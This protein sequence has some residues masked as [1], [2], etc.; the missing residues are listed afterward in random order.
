MSAVAPGQERAAAPAP[1][2]H[3]LLSIAHYHNAEHLANDERTWPI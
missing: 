1:D 2:H 3:E